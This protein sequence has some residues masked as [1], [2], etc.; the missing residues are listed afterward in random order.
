LF[1]GDT[2]GS[3]SKENPERCL[4][5]VTKR[6]KQGKLLQVRWRGGDELSRVLHKD[7]RVEK[8]KSNVATILA[9]LL[10]EGQVAKFEAADKSKWPKDFFEALVKSDWREWIS[11]VKKEIASW[12]DFNAYSVIDIEEKTVGASIVPLGELYTRKRDLSYKFRQYLM[13]NLLKQGKDFYETF[14]ST[15]SWDG[16]RWC[17]SVACATGKKIY[18]LDAVTGFLQASEQFDLYAFVPS[19]GDYSSLS[20]EDLAVFRGQ[21]LEMIQK[22][23]EQGLKRFANLH[24]KSSRVNPKKCYRLN[25]SIYGAPSANYEWEALFQGTHTKHC[26]LTLSQVEPSLFV[27]I[28]VDKDDRVVEWLIAKIWTDDVRYFGTEAMRI[29]Y[30][31]KLG[32]KI[33]VKFLGV[34]GEFVGTD[35]SQDIERGLCELKS[36]KYWELAAERFKEHFPQG[37]KERRNALTVSDEKVMFEVVSDE[38]YEQAKHLPYRELCGVISYP[39]A[40]S[41]LEMRYCVSICGSHRTKW[42]VKQFTVLKKAFE[43]GFATREIG[44]IYSQG[45]D[46]HGLNTIYCFADAGHSVPRSQGCSVVLMNGAAISLTSKKHTITASSTCHDELIQF[47]IAC[48]KVVGFR[49][50]GSE[51]GMFQTA[52]TIIYQDNEA[53]VQIAKHRGSLSSRS[54]HLDLKVLSS[55]NKVEDGKV[56]PVI[57]GT[58]EMYADIGTK[59]LPDNQFVYL[60]DK[61]N[62]YSL[63]KKFHPTYELPSFVT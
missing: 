30:E 12:L 27:K 53:A 63:V 9:V 31:E 59:A 19:H 25:S 45:L 36:P 35:F 60:R 4:G 14:S 46:S 48:N 33:K 47:S 10:V 28:R 40:C 26:G 44:L 13:G 2:P 52:P 1:D 57:K 6:W 51:M 18:G 5:V 37:M 50:L 32:Q 42:G 8:K 49:N 21:L 38:D 24:R 54:K 11:A 3:W 41:K 43:Y 39:A 16:I 29:D 34:P 20:F 15:V 17:A 58:A 22:E 61:L 55:R 56:V 7:I 62:G 23:G